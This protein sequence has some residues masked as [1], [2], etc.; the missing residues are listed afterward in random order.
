M[1]NEINGRS[2]YQKHAQ[3]TSS[4]NDLV[5]RLSKI[6]VKFITQVEGLQQPGICNYSNI[7]FT[8]GVVFIDFG[9]VEPAVLGQLQEAARQEAALPDE[10][11]V[12]RVGRLAFGV[13]AV[14]ALH[15][16][17]NEFVSEL[18]MKSDI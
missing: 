15:Q 18:G 5:E 12:L 1:T 11:E 7:S 17:L 2:L 6:P 16:Q 3:S 9:F 10:I 8:P 13:D 14:A 4:Q